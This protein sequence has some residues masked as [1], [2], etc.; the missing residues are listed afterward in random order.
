MDYL[1]TQCASKTLLSGSIESDDSQIP[2]RRCIHSPTNQLRKLS[3]AL[4]TCR[5]RTKDRFLLFKLTLLRHGQHVVERKGVRTGPA[6]SCRHARF[7]IPHDG[8]GL[9]SD[10]TCASTTSS[11]SGCAFRVHTLHR[12]T[13]SCCS[14]TPF[15]EPSH[16]Y[17]NCSCLVDLVWDQCI[18]CHWLTL[19]IAG[20][21]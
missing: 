8:L 7:G 4:L 9:P 3:A 20:A 6:L 11:S 16:D 2:F 10:Q 15:S 12:V 19:Q 14:R 13:R 5:S 1:G 21:T 17:A 18:T